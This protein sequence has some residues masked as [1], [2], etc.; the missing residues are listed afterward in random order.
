[1]QQVF[2]LVRLLVRAPV[3]LPDAV[4]DFTEEINDMKILQTVVNGTPRYMLDRT[5][6]WVAQCNNQRA[7]GLLLSVGVKVPMRKLVIMMAETGKVGAL[8]FLLEEVGVPVLPTQIWE[9]KALLSPRDD[10]LRAMNKVWWAAGGGMLIDRFIRKAWGEEKY[11]Y[12]LRSK[13]PTAFMRR[14]YTPMCPKCK[15]S[16]FPTLKEIARTVITVCVCKAQSNLY[17]M[18]RIAEIPQELKQFLVRDIDIKCLK[19]VG[20]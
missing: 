4:Q 13:R 1:M 14:R 11:F 9:G 10:H 6:V 15:K 3:Q 2:R 8:A 7:I 12:R 16:E 17:Y 19:Y 18:A 5:M 20:F